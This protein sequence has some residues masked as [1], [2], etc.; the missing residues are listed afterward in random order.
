MHCLRVNSVRHSWHDM[1]LGLAVFWLPYS[2][3]QSKP[4]TNLLTNVL[5]VSVKYTMLPSV[6]RNVN[7]LAG[8][9]I[10]AGGLT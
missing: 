7:A 9:R 5:I 10:Q 6:L 3:H 1:K 8:P 2:D 4:I